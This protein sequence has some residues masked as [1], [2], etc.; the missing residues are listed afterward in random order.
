M[1][2]N[3][4]WIDDDEL[5]KDLDPISRE[6]VTWFA[7]MHADEV[8]A[9]TRAA[10][11]AWL[12]RDV[13]HQTAYAD[14]E[15]MWSGAS[16]LP[17]VKAH[18]RASRIHMTRRTFGKAA[19]AAAIGGGGWLAYQQ[20]FLGDYRTGTGERRSVRLP[21]NSNV[22]LAGATALSLDFRPQLRLVTLHKGE[23]FFSTTPD[24]ARPFVVDAG[25]GRTMASGASFNIDYAADDDV[26]VTVLENAADVRLGI[27][28]VRVSAGRQ[29]SYGRK[30]MG[31]PNAVDPDEALAWREGRL[32]FV[33]APFGRVV[34]SLNRWR[35]GKLLIVSPSLVERPVTLI[36]DLDRIGDI[37]DVLKDSLPIR[38]VNVT[39][40]VTLIMAV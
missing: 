30:T 18:R 9:S 22:E 5:D 37:P 7:A 36:V 33:S 19:I 31:V 15:R 21:D 26:H 12:R 16:E 23:A 24:A 14:V 32:V 27:A 3:P 2:N 11:R 28:D 6:A 4:E 1:G 35:S 39:P 17:L 25:A 13:R 20:Y 38:L 40:Y 8:A 34:A 10:F 29:V